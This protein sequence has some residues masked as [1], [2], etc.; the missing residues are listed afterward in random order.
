MYKLVILTIAV[1]LS[2]T[3]TAQ[4]VDPTR[5]LSAS[6]QVGSEIKTIT[7]M[8]LQSI[9]DSEKALTVVIN[10]KVLKLG[11]RIEQYQLKKINKKSVVLSAADKRLELSLYSP[12]IA[13]HNEK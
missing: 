10:G 9:V 11:D 7:V 3:V 2:T 12:V 13:T 1:M 8:Q 4:E 6:G 5:P